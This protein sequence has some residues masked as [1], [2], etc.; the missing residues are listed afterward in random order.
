MNQGVVHFWSLHRDIRNFS[1]HPTSFWPDRWLIASGEAKYDGPAD[2]PFVHNLN[3]FV[4]FSFGP[5]NCVG[6][7]LAMQEMRMVVC[8]FMQRLEFKF[9]EDWNPDEF[10][11][12]LCDFFVSVREKVPVTV[13][14]RKMA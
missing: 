10:D 3:A 7:N 8:L 2:Q 11:H 9:A 5:S 12:G 4:P 13:K 6:K 1:P 14:P